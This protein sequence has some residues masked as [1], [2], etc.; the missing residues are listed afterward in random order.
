MQF[1]CLLW[2]KFTNYIFLIYQ[3]HIARACTLEYNSYFWVKTTCNYDILLDQLQP[4]G[5][6]SRIVLHDSICWLQGMRIPSYDNQLLALAED[7]AQRILPAFDTPTGI[8]A[9]YKFVC[10][11]CLG[12]VFCS[13]Y[14]PIC[15]IPCNYLIISVA[16]TLQISFIGLPSS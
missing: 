5:F 1:E 3:W 14:F 4:F 12:K 11:A 16:K 15:S 10:T 13:F 9:E 6:G 8:V 2:R 7:L